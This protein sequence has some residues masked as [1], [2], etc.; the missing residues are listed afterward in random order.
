MS[1]TLEDSS[2]NKLFAIGKNNGPTGG[3]SDIGGNMVG[4]QQVAFGT[5]V[6]FSTLSTELPSQYSAGLADIRAVPTEF[7]WR[8]DK[9]KGGFISKPGNQGLCGSCWAISAAGI[10]GDNFVVSGL[11]TDSEGNKFVPDISTTWILVNY[12]QSQCEGGNPGTAFQQIASSADN[13]FGGLV[14]NHCLD[15]SWCSEDSM[16][17]GDSKKHFRANP[18]TLNTLIPMK[19]GCYFAG[20]KFLFKLDQQPNSIA[21]GMK[22]KNGSII[23]ESDWDR[24][25]VDIK[26]HIMTKGPV[27][28]GFL[29]FDN[30]MAGTFTKGQSNKGIYLE[31]LTYP[32]LP[33]LA[34]PKSA[35]PTDPVNFK[36]SHAVA[37]IGWGTED[38]VE[39]SPGKKETVEYWYC[40]NSWTEKWGDGGYFKMAM[41]PHNKLSQFDKQVTIKN[42]AEGTKQAGGIVSINVTKKPELV[43]INQVTLA[44]GHRE[45]IKLA[46]DE[47]YYKGNASSN[48]AGPAPQ[49]SG[50]QEGNSKD[51]RKNI[52]LLCIVLVV[53]LMGV[54]LVTYFTGDKTTK[55]KY[56]IPFVV[57]E[58]ILLVILGFLIYFVINI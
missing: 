45:N 10:I 39:T 23:K 20:K 26:K 55:Q 9:E 4:V 48:K 18:M 47:S 54:L 31:N 42:K 22:T 7:N 13:K 11:N 57:A 29:V 34:K 1:I 17:N 33:N 43:D 35:N 30:F 58:A 36:G 28:G 56:T 46:K 5:N 44:E 25:K 53:I 16:C 24:Y 49:N 8:Y 32:G 51:S 50:K 2:E 15:Y 12:G 6:D 41:Y 3:L 19:E 40:R 37:I 52:V 14:T 21:I 27:L 38:D